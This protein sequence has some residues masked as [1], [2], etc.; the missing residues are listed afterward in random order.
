M[1]A[2]LKARRKQVSPAPG[3][4]TLRRLKEGEV[5]RAGDWCCNP[6]ADPVRVIT[7]GVKIHAK[8]WPHYRIE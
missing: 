6:N 1:T 2:K 8:H 5:I 4:A 7:G 3:I